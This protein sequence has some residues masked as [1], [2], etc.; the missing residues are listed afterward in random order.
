MKSFVRS[1]Y[2]FIL[3]TLLMILVSVM[4][5]NMAN[6]V[7]GPTVT[8]ISPADGAALSTASVL[9]SADFYD[10]GN[11]S[12]AGYSMKL[13]GNPV[14]VSFSY[15]DGY[16]DSCSGE[17]ITQD[18]LRAKLTYN[19][20]GLKDGL[21][22]VEVQMNNAAG[23]PVVKTWNFTVS[24]KPTITSL[25][26]VNNSKI[27]DAN[28]SITATL[29]DNDGIDQ[30]AIVVEVDGNSVPFTFNA[31]TGALS[32][33]P[34]SPWT[35][36]YHKAYISV[37][38]TT[39][40]Q[41]TSQWGFYIT[42]EGPVITFPDD[43]KNYTTT[44]PY[45]SGNFYSEINLNQYATMKIDGVSVSPNFQ[46]AGYNDSCSGEFIVTSYQSGTFSFAASGLTNGMHILEIGA[47]DSAGKTTTRQFTFYVGSANPIIKFN[48]ATYIVDEGGTAI[49]TVTRAGYLNKITKVNYST[50]N[51]TAA[52]GVNYIIASGTLTFNAGETSKT[53]SVATIDENAYEAA[54]TVNLKLSSPSGAVFGTPITAVLTINDN[55]TAPVVQFST[56][57]WDVAEGSN[58]TITVTRSGATGGAS[59]VNYA[60][61]DGT[62]QAGINYSSA[63]GTLNFAAGETSKTFT[64]SSLDDIFYGS[65]TTVN[66]T[67][68]SPVGA[69]VGTPANAVLTIT[70]NDVPPVLQFSAATYSATEGGSATIT[71]ARSGAVGGSTTVEYETAAGG[72]ASMGQDYTGT[73]GTLTFG[74]GETTKTFIVTTIHNNIYKG[75]QTVNLALSNP[76]GG[77]A[78]IQSTAVLQ[79]NE[80]DEAPLIQFGESSYTVN[81]GTAVNINVTRAGATGV[82]SKAQYAT[83]NGTAKSGVKY[84]AAV[85]T[86]T[87]NPGE[88]TKSITIA[89]LDEKAYDGDSTFSVT[90]SSPNGA[91]LG[92]PA[93]TVVTIKDNDTAPVIQFSLAAYS[94]TEG[95]KATI[96]VTRS[97]ATAGTSTVN[98]AASD[99]TAAAEIKYTPVSGTLTFNPG[100][101]KK[102]FTVIT[103]NNTIFEGNQTVNITLSDPVS[104]ILGAIPSALLTVK[105]NDAVPVVQLKAAAYTVNEGVN[106]TLI[107]TRT[108][109]TG[110]ISTVN[111][112]TG[113][114]TAKAG[115][116]YAA[117]TGTITFNPGETSKNIIVEILDDTLY[118]GT[119]VSLNLTLSSP[120]GAV[121]GTRASAVINIKDNDTPPTVKLS[122]TAYTVDEGNDATIT[123]TRTGNTGLVSSI[124]YTAS[125]GTAVSDRDYTA[126]NGILIFE[127]GETSK[128]ITVP[129]LCNNQYL[130]RITVKVSLSGPVNAILGRPNAATLNINEVDKPATI[131]LNASTYSV[132]EGRDITINITRAD[133]LGSASSVKYAA[134]AGT[135]KAGVD[136]TAA[137]GIITFAPGESV[138]S[139]VLSTI[140]NTNYA[141]NK[142]FK[143]TLS[144][145]VNASLGAITSTIVTIADDEKSLLRFTTTSY[146]GEEGTD[147]T[148]NV[149]RIGD[150][151]AT[152]AV[153]YSTSNGTAVD[154]QDYNGA[155]G[156]LTFNPGETIKSFVVSTI[157]NNEMSA[158]KTV[159]LTLSGA[160]G[161]AVN[162]TGSRIE[163][164]LSIADIDLPQ[165]T[166]I[167]LELTGVSFPTIGGTTYISVMGVYKEGF[168]TD[169]SAA[170]T[171]TSSV[172]RVATVSA[173]NITGVAK[174]TSV[175]TVKFGKYSK[176]FSV[177]IK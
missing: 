18:Y 11:I 105:D 26:P 107:V 40:N 142:T 15:T 27:P 99:G 70:D 55:D 22:T 154:G 88:T 167:G 153:N 123:V 61:S 44:N 100:D 53:F 132:E 93:A 144:N 13:N 140:D 147:I 37:K 163:S 138:K 47:Q 143:V 124:N 106:A 1:K 19:A 30:S 23:V 69:V 175:I 114:G 95:G 113:D 151:G 170:A 16:W 51:G 28:A 115:N 31:S 108:G 33:S 169:I 121:L 116:E 136:Y 118:E 109:A 68:S 21:Q 129:T 20:I 171:W 159:N 96:I 119:N 39:G 67:L 157:H 149:E 4:A 32:V 76:V 45:L 79:I 148:V 29:R 156:T 73:T 41:T 177:V 43:G 97:G 83:V 172:S 38:D 112:A 81:E 130:G 64:V 135:A 24:V 58:A 9:I 17:F 160:S 176:R 101:T 122:S 125:D 8:A 2:V 162:G 54:R 120:T 111:Y 74:P 85:G 166:L 152:S 155:S 66:L 6:A 10:S 110:G 34:A 158:A 62:A 94:V 14:P 75:V 91:D 146:T 150:T 127:A 72:S 46:Y 173:G 126:V 98:Y 164:L 87:F 25:Y 82:V 5:V 52:A 128:T 174:G 145:P 133:N 80:A 165:G 137:S 117:G 139:I 65:N 35:N 103:L 63:A 86:V 48:S 56:A 12:N 77:T 90:L 131:A 89:T 102:T 60:S 42:A 3:L 50:S 71:V 36:D 141:V 57:S 168:K 7:A 161:G 92:T 49:I 78:G 134:T 84:T 104:S 59:K